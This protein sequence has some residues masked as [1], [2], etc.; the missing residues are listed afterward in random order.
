MAS[1]ERFA[2]APN[3]HLTPPSAT[4]SQFQDFKAR[5]G[6]T[7]SVLTHGLSYGDDCSS[8]KSFVAELGRSS[9]VGVGVIDPETVTP[10]ELAAMQA[11]GVRGIRVN[12]YKYGA[13]HDVERQKIALRQHARILRRYCPH[14]SMAFTHVHPEFWGDLKPVIEGEICAPGIRL[15]TDHFALLKGASMLPGTLASAPA[16]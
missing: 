6:I 4:I 16:D 1:A 13:M 8:L 7:H 5:L 15:I 12:L 14:W 11:A 10:E 3:R 9:T 2:Y